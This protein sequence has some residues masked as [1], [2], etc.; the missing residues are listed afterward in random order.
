MNEIQHFIIIYAN[1]FEFHIF[2]NYSINI[3]K[4]E[5]EAFFI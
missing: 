5:K 2:H 1:I 4:N 3:K